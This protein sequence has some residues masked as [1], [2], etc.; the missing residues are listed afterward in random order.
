MV[1]NVFSAI[2]VFLLLLSFGISLYAENNEKK[3]IL[4]K[5]LRNHTSTTEK[6][7]SSVDESLLNAKELLDIGLAFYRKNYF[8]KSE[9]YFNKA[10]EKN[11]EYYI[12]YDYMGELM[13]KK[14]DIV[15]ARAT[16]REAFTKNKDNAD[17]CSK[18]AY[19][20]EFNDKGE[21]YGKGYDYDKCVEYYTKAIEINQKNA[22]TYFNKAK[23]SFLAGNDEEALNLMKSFVRIK[24]G[25]GEAYYYLGRIY[26]N[27]NSRKT[28]MEYYKMSLR[29][30]CSNS[31]WKK[32]LEERMSL[33]FAKKK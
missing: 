32:D 24:I 30:S 21:R 13:L 23:A 29:N 4:T 9:Y 16:F 6:K 26:E 8:E 27:R 28:A 12:I 17:F 14:K 19:T 22:E 15:R 11:P 18:I 25:E 1:K 20:Y 5:I 3:N 7:I 10:L 31:T 2:I 33:A